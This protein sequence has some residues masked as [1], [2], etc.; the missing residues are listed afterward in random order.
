MPVEE[1]GNMII[2]LAAIARIDG[3]ADFAAT[4]WPTVTKWAKYLEAKGF[5]PENQLCTDDFA[6]HLAHNAN[7]SIKSIEALA[8]Y[9]LLC[10]M[11]ADQENSEKYRNMAKEFADKWLKAADDG[12]HYRLTFDKPGTWSQ[13][14]NMIWDKVLGLDLFPREVVE[15]EIAYYRKI[16]D[17]FGVALDSR[18][19]YAKVDWSVWTA[20]LAFSREDF[21]AIFLPVYEF[22]DQVPERNPIT[23]L[24]WTKTG[25]ETGMHARPVIGGVFM[26]ML[27]EPKVWKKWARRGEN[28]LGEW[29]ILPLA[30]RTVELVKT[31]AKEPLVWRYTFE[32][33]SEFWHLREF[34]DDA[35]KE[36]VG[37]FGSKGTPNSV[38]R[39]EWKTK[40]IWM[41]REFKMP[42]TPFNNPEFLMYHDEDVEIFIN[43]VLAASVGG[44]TADYELIAMTPDAKAAL[45]PGANT[46]AVHCRQT[47]GGQYIDVGIVDSLQTVSLP[48][49]RP[50]FD[51][52]LRDPSICVGPDR[53][54]YLIG[55]TGH[56]TWWQTNEGIRMW[57]SRDLKKWEPLGLVWSFEKDATWQKGST[58]NDGKLRRAIWAPEIHYI[59]K[60]YWIT[61]CVNYGG[62]GLLKST[63]GKAEG[64]YV[65][66]KAD[67]PLTP[68]ID[69]SLFQD[70]DGTVYFVY[71]NGKIA[72]M[73]DDMSGLAEDARLLKPANASQVGFEGAFLFKAN[74]LYHLVCA[75]QNDGKYY[76][77]MIAWS[78]TLRGPYSER[79]LAIPHGGH[80]MIFKDRDNQWWSTFFGSDGY[81]PFTERPAILRVQFTMDGKIYP[82]GAIR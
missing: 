26:K 57:K 8:A 49:V 19:P 63:S 33:P 38:V 61:Y 34:K 77:C 36:G 52:P 12:D 72:R 25:H 71:Q 14:Y 69:A 5:D 24:Y 79:Y 46:I 32:Q 31:S 2:L 81:A 23:D 6:G 21:D 20:A 76:D 10:G 29:A 73:K 13:K 53:M 43:A 45:K 44:F 59:K 11:R 30:Q 82:K 62:T 64:P 39:T 60:N 3:N 75:E 58:G 15:K 18:K 41:R 50:M 74:G 67:G 55:T 54:Y 68:E 22:A 78:P 47:E 65:D 48:S 1:S 17:Q 51:Y 70:D 35:W 27:T 9:G 4:Y 16:K 42:E 7:L 37:G 80:N 28:K 40:D 56:P 66:V